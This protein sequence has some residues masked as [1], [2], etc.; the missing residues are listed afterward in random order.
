MTSQPQTKR[1]GA[2]T[3]PQF[4]VAA[5]KTKKNDED[6]GGDMSAGLPSGS[7]TT[8]RSN[9]KL[10][11]PWTAAVTLTVPTGSGV[12]YTEA[13]ARA[14]R[15][16][17]LSNLRNAEIRLRGAIMG[18]L[19]LEIQGQERGRG[20]EKASILAQHMAAVFYILFSL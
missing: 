15:E 6:A 8:R 17:N 16:M 7:G 11:Q 14:R 4:G 18:I 9:P 20:C 19:I 1:A 13:M 12:T 3:A 10:S 2:N 5:K